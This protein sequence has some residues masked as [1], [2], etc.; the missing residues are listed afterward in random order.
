MPNVGGVFRQLLASAIAL[1]LKILGTALPM[2]VVQILAHDGQDYARGAQVLLRTRVDQR[3]PLDRVRPRHHLG[4]GVDDQ[5]RVLGPIDQ[6]VAVHG[7]VRADVQVR[8]GRIGGPASGR[9]VELGALAG[10][11]DAD[12]LAIGALGSARRFLRPLATY[13]VVRVAGQEVHRDGVEQLRCPAL[14]EQ[15]VVRLGHGQQLPAERD[16]L[17]EDTVELLATVAALGDTEPL[18]LIV[19]QGLGGRFQNLCRQ[20]GGAGAEVEYAVAHA[21]S[22]PLR[23][24]DFKPPGVTVTPGAHRMHR[25]RRSAPSW[26]PEPW[27]PPASPS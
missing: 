8:R 2:R 17:V 23:G 9:P 20:H 5:V 6:T 24:P 7:L 18:A 25:R 11:D 15:D 1:K 26:V 21:S 4:A 10:R 14:Q 12:L 16:R 13:D 22:L 19:Q 27:S 3:C